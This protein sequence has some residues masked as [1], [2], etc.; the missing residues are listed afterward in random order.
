MEQQVHDIDEASNM[1]CPLTFNNRNGYQFCRTSKCMAWR[2][3]FFEGSQNDT[4]GYCGMARQ[5]P[6]TAQDIEDTHAL[7]QAT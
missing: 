7:W 3:S 5:L 4:H 1:W 2:W 6:Y